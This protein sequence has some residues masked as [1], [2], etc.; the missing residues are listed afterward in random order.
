LPFGGLVGTSPVHE[1]TRAVPD[2]TNAPT[3]HY[4]TGPEFATARH[5]PCNHQRD[6]TDHVHDK[7]L[8]KLGSF[9]TPHQLLVVVNH[10]AISSCYVYY[11][12]IITCRTWLYLSRETVR[13]VVKKVISFDITFVIWCIIASLFSHEQS[14]KGFLKMKTN[15]VKAAM[16]RGEA[17]FGVWLGIPSVFTARLLARSSYDWLVVDTEHAPTDVT[18]MSQ[19]VGTIADAGGVPVVRIAANTVE[20]IKRALDSGTWGLV[21]PMVNTKEEA[22][23]AIQA[24]KYPPVGERSIGGAYAAMG[25]GTSRA[26]YYNRANDEIL[27]ILQIE[28]KQAVENCEEIM[29]VPGIDVIFIG[30]N[31]LHASLGLQPRSESDEPIF[32]AALDKVKAAA[33]ARNIPLGIYASN[34][35]AAAAR[36]A[37]GFQFISAISDIAALETGITL[38]LQAAKT[39]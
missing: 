13:R 1:D 20:N 6:V 19:M 38:H 34:G 29:D 16:Q 14:G 23:A 21:V 9:S 28:S 32:N 8:Q 24:A 17:T 7:M 2:Q 22:V 37:E 11:Q 30:P 35:Q 10:R 25:F 15:H 31:D 5:R 26:E 39:Q 3:G 18:V 12:T 33:R 4:P 36:A 27:V